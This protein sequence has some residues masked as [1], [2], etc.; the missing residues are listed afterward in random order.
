MT[1]IPQVRR[2]ARRIQRS[3]APPAPQQRRPI[4]ATV[5]N[6]KVTRADS[7]TSRQTEYVDEFELAGLGMSQLILPTPYPVN[8]L[9]EIIEHSNMLGQCIASWVVNTVGTGWE[10]VP[11]HKKVTKD[12]DEEDELQS[13]IDFANSEESLS[14][15]MKK[16]VA[17]KEAVGFGFVEVIRDA[18][19]DIAL[20]R[21]ASSLYMRLG[22]KHPDE[23][24]VKYDVRRGKRVVTVKEFRKFRR[25]LQ[26]IAGRITFFKELGDPR[27][28]NSLTGYYEGESGFT[29]DSPATEILHLRLQSN[30]PYGVPRWLSQLPN[31]I[32]SREAEEVNMRYFEDNTI[33]SG[34]LTIAGGRLTDESMRNLTNTLA[35]MTAREA[36]NKLTVIEA[37]GEAE[38]LDA[39]NTPV[40]MKLERL[41]DARPTDS[42][43]AGYDEAN[44][45]KVRS[46]F[47]LPS[48]A[49]G[50]ANEHNFATANVAMF[51]AESQ[52]FAPE[53]NEVDEVLNNKLV[54]PRHG[55]RLQTVKL[56]GRTPAITSPE[57]QIKTM[58]ALNVMG[59]L[60]PRLAQKLANTMLQIEIEEYPPVGHKDW[61]EW[62][63]QP[64]AL[65]TGGAK[66]H[67]GQNQKDDATKETEA[68]GAISSQPK[69]GEE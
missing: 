9:F 1:S 13:F 57:G 56:A 61:K 20:M 65:S 52:V 22:H 27:K 41:N 39:N 62:M 2:A 8:R 69:H 33:P 21:H 3:G 40:T 49:V 4:T 59:A 42:L 46:S 58:T 51:A 53:R 50:M 32:G 6:I 43:F 34:L 12:E 25:F 7:N 14:T 64:M 23:V 10:V 44:Q 5:T 47:R 63:D 17:H 11:A 16:A 26:L 38:S 35:G 28:M 18:K 60:T 29:D 68:S 24:L 67:A 15:V 66:T 48:V 55:L 37:I 19:G 54:F 45:S 36:Q 30:D 31:I